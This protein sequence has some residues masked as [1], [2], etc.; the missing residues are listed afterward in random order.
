M[1]AALAVLVVL[2]APGDAEYLCGE[3]EI[4]LTNPQ[5]AAFANF[6]NGVAPAFSIATSDE[7]RCSRDTGMCRLLDIV[8]ITDEQLIDADEQGIAGDSVADGGGGTV[9]H[10]RIRWRSMS[11]DDRTRLDAYL[12]LVHPGATHRTALDIVWRR[13]TG[14][15]WSE[16]IVHRKQAPAAQYKADRVAKRVVQFFRR[17]P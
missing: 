14:S 6:A 10:Q 3:D 17:S 5:R 8:T 7:F 15:V 13:T 2:A 1:I 4:T 9:V 12:A 11:D 16:K